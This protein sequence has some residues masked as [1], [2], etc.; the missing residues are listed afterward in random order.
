MIE[1]LIPYDSFAHDAELEK[2]DK[3]GGGNSIEFSELNQEQED[4]TLQ[5][6]E[7]KEREQQLC[8]GWLFCQLLLLL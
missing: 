6:T 7:E 3:E 5:R 4:E 8:V 2:Y 1:Q